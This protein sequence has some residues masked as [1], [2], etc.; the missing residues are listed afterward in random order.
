MSK[1]TETPEAAI[2]RQ[3]S[4]E[5]A[6]EIIELK[7]F[8]T[9]RIK[10][11]GYAH[12]RARN[13]RKRFTAFV[14]GGTTDGHPAGSFHASYLG[15]I[16]K[17][18]HEWGFHTERIVAPG[19]NT[20]IGE[21]DIYVTLQGMVEP[22]ELHR[23]FDSSSPQEMGSASNPVHTVLRIAQPVKMER[24]EVANS[25]TNAYNDPLLLTQTNPVGLRSLI[26]AVTLMSSL[27]AIV[28]MSILQML[29]K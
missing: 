1:P 17:Q 11:R 28:A 15:V 4:A 14:D 23:L 25:V 12:L 27:I 10:E 7:K 13:D 20:Q 29:V 2:Q 24:L 3:L 22:R 19:T 9:S 21:C 16:M 8:L 5:I 18:I 26:V 6:I